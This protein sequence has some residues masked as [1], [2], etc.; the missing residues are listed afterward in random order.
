MPIECRNI[1]VCINEKQERRKISTGERVLKLKRTMCLHT[2]FL[3]PA[4]HCQTFEIRGRQVL[5]AVH[6]VKFVAYLCWMVKLVVRTTS[7]V[8]EHLMFFFSCLCD[9]VFDGD[10]Y[11]HGS[12]NRCSNS[13]QTE[14]VQSVTLPDLGGGSR[15]A[16]N[17]QVCTISA[18]FSS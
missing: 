18:V 5:V 17:S 15:E 14:C 7:C 10:V 9:Q 1:S 16:L 3:I 13:N 8:H 12:C 2:Y 4:L 11:A 6:S